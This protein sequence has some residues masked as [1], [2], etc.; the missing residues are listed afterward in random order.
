[1]TL[2][3]LIFTDKMAAFYFKLLLQL[4]IRIWPLSV[5]STYGKDTIGIWKSPKVY[6]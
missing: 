3:E 1:M 4:P 6:V 5:V 2:S